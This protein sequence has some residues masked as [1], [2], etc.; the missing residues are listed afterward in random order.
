ME[1]VEKY[2]QNSFLP[3]EKTIGIPPSDIADY[4]DK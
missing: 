2:K 4:Y 1:V 3:E